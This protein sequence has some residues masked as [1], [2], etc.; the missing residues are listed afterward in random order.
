MLMLFRDQ[1]SNHACL[2]IL[3]PQL[4]RELL[5]LYYIK[6]SLS[7]NPLLEIQE[8]VHRERVLLIRLVSEQ[9]ESQALRP[10]LGFYARQNRQILVVLID[11]QDELF[12]VLLPRVVRQGDCYRL[13]GGVLPL[14]DQILSV[15]VNFLH[16]YV[17]CLSMGVRIFFQSLE[18]G[19]RFQIPVF[20]I[21]DRGLYG[22]RER[23]NSCLALYDAGMRLKRPL[24]CHFGFKR[25]LIQEKQ[26]EA[27]PQRFGVS[28][29]SES[30]SKA[31]EHPLPLLIIKSVVIWS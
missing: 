21:Q 20:Q 12:D 23:L 31:P 1:D 11:S 9:K 30:P 2:D 13:G 25:S 22:K 18:N 27:E 10:Q 24:G 16:E 26:R 8:A 5:V 17:N 3:K 6:I 28:K 4:L 15:L 7:P 14:D 19:V 29:K